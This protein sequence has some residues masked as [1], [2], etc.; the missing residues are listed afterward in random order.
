MES[1]FFVSSKKK[2]SIKINN[3]F[4]DFFFIWGA[5]WKKKKSQEHIFFPSEKYNAKNIFQE[6]PIFFNV[7]NQV[8]KRWVKKKNSVIFKIFQ[9][10]EDIFWTKW[11]K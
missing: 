10:S 1:G 7:W 9:I 5:E 2:I 8:A 11:K 6:L 4:Q 3:S